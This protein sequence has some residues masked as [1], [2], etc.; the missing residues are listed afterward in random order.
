MSALDLA[1]MTDEQFAHHQF[2]QAVARQVA[3]MRADA[4][5]MDSV[6]QTAAAGVLRRHADR[7]ESPLDHNM[8][9]S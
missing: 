4:D 7:L 5:F 3:D 9:T 1:A 8:N 2:R 6:N